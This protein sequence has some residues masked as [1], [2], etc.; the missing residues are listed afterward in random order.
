MCGSFKALLINS[1][2]SL[3]CSSLLDGQFEPYMLLEKKYFAGSI[4][5]IVQIVICTN[6]E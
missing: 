1:A 5:L 4:K 3:L 6:L 2:S